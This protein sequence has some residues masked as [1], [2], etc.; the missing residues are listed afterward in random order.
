MAVPLT[1]PAT[2]GS[3]ELPRFASP[4]VV[5]VVESEVNVNLTRLLGS[6]PA[7]CAFYWDICAY[8]L[9]ECPLLVVDETEECDE[10]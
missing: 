5:S 4:D 3:T 1:P 10:S 8:V 7:V 9:W 6:R 2:W